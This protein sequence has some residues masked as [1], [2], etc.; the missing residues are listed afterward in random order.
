MMFVRPGLILVF[1][2]LSDALFAV[3]PIWPGPDP[4][5]ALD[6]AEER[7]EEALR[8]LARPAAAPEPSVDLSEPAL[9]PTLPAGD[10]AAM[11]LKAKDYI[12]AGDVFQ[13]VLA[14][15]FTC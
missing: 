9:T 12:A 2:R 11:V 4:A 1:D 3:A 8:K 7:I 6:A 15:R 14:Q 10:Y 13:V 5:R